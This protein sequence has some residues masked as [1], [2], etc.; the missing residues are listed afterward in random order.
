MKANKTQQKIDFFKYI[1]STSHS[2]L[3]LH[4]QASMEPYYLFYNGNRGSLSIQGN[5]DPNDNRVICPYTYCTDE[6]PGI[7]VQTNY[8]LGP[9]SMLLN[10]A[11]KNVTSQNIISELSTKVFFSILFLQLLCIVR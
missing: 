1:P 8:I 5:L 4:K 9:Q 10:S 6:S 2:D 3:F 7:Y 11:A